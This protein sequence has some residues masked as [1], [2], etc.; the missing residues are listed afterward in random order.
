VTQ[1]T[2]RQVDWWSVHI[3]VQPLLARVGAWPM[4][5][6]PAWSDLDDADPAKIAALYD[7]ARHHALR[8]DTAQTALAEA[9]RAVAAAVNWT[10]VARAI[11][12][13]RDMYI[14]RGTGD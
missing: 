12:R 9:S 13:R 1:Q 6:T 2:S 3:H 5:G 11:Q 7:A 8:V 4:A 10:V 14:P